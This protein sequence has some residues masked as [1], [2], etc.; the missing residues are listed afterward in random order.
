[1]YTY[2]TQQREEHIMKHTGEAKEVSWSDGQ[3]DGHLAI[4]NQW[5]PLRVLNCLIYLV[6]LSSHIRV[7]GKY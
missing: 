5:D 4:R 7:E 6:W 3:I 1:M 2:Y